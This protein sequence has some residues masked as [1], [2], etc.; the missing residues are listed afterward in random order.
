MAL[1]FL[2]AEWE[3]LSAEKTGLG[4]KPYLLTT[5]AS[6]LADLEW[7]PADARAAARDMMSDPIATCA[8]SLEIF[9]EKVQGPG[10]PSQPT[11]RQKFAWPAREPE[12]DSPVFEEEAQGRVSYFANSSNYS[13]S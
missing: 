2:D 13:R 12:D 9:K 7:S 6:T 11:L 1:S 4:I 10:E 8:T 5:A 3:Y